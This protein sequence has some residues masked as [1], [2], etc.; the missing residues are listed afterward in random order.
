MTH[1]QIQIACATEMGLGNRWVLMKRGLYYRPNSA[2]YT[3][4]VNEAGIYSEEE[5]NKH[6]YPYDEPVT[7]HPAPLPPYPTDANAALTLV[8][9][10]AK[11]GFW[12]EFKR[13]ETCWEAR[14][15]QKEF[16]RG[17]I[18]PTLPEAISGAFL[19][20]VGKWEEGEP[21]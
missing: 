20:V 2:G 12:W 18:A 13:Y 17:Y 9:H 3:A 16:T 10:L 7:K 21:N 6:V 19:K 1:E 8:E 11:E 5:A 15:W 14:A 4:F